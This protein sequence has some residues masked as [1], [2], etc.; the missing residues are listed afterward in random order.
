MEHVVSLAGGG[1]IVRER[2]GMFFLVCDG[3]EIPHTSLE[4]ARA[5][6]ERMLKLSHV[7]VPSPANVGYTGWIHAG[8]VE[9]GLNGRNYVWVMENEYW[10]E[11]LL[12]RRGRTQSGE[13]TRHD[14][15]CAGLTLALAGAVQARGGEVG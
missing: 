1:M 2:D 6:A 13:Y 9:A 15:A 4:N 5:D 12:V 11:G 8:R 7:G 14:E 10:K 3:Y